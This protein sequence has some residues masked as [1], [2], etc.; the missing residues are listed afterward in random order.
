M[1]GGLWVGALAQDENGG[2]TGVSTSAVDGSQGSAS[3]DATE[4]TPVS[5]KITVRSTLPNS[6]YYNPKAISELDYSSTFWDGVAKRALGNNEDHRPMSLE[7]RQTT[8]PI[9][10]LRQLRDLPLHDQE[11]RSA[12]RNVWVGM[13]D[14]LQSG[15]KNAYNCWPPSSGCA[16]SAA[17]SR[18]SRSATPTRCASSTRAT[19][20]TALCRTDLA[21]PMAGVM[22]FG[23][24]P[25]PVVDTVAD[26]K[27]VSLSVWS[28]APATPRVTRTSRSTRS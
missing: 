7:V 3:A 23:V 6:R 9:L 10:G 11:R 18:R 1:R 14:E 19:Q 17:G 8:T 4:F 26:H 25:V 28:Y 22:P 12:A 5:P 21:P 15:N 24:R 2:F 13:Y 27:Q 16:R 20:N